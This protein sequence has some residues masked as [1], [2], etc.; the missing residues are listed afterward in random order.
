[1]RLEHSK[2][3]G[4]F[5]GYIKTLESILPP[6]YA[7]LCTFNGRQFTVYSILYYKC[8]FSSVGRATDL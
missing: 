3:D 2:N 7:A 4:N 1:M 8:R 5:S 6:L